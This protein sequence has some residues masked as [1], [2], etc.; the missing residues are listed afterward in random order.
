MEYDFLKQKR[1][2][3]VDNEQELI[4]MLMSIL[5]EEGYENLHTANS[6]KEAVIKAAE[7]QPELAVLDVMLSDIASLTRGYLKDYPT[8]TGDG[9]AGLT[10]VGFPKTS[11]WKHMYNSWD[12]V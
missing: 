10:V 4:Y 9:K 8:F 3:L 5:K 1:I 2:L 11:Y 6:V 12:Y 7:V